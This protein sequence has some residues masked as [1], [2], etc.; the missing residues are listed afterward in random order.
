MENDRRPRYSPRPE[1]AKIFWK[2]LVCRKNM[3]YCNETFYSRQSTVYSL[4]STVYILLST[5]YS[6]QSML[7]MTVRDRRVKCDT[8]VLWIIVWCITRRASIDR[9]WIIHVICSR[10]VTTR[11]WDC[12]D[13]SY[14]VF[15]AN[16]WD[17]SQK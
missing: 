8:L 11:L 12:P 17:A 10:R 7:N 1:M 13:K 5:V 2:I 6:L 3:K 14:C 4:Q 16:R 15:C 9:I